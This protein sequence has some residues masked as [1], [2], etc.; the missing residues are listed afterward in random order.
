MAAGP[1]H[2]ASARTPQKTP[3]STVILLW[4]DVATTRDRAENTS[5]NIYSVIACY[6]AV[7]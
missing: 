5:S 4:N 7:I 3:L 2:I 1:R 6:A